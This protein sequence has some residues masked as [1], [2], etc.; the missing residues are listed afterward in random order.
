QRK[1]LIPEV[2]LPQHRGNITIADVLQADPGPAR[3]AMIRQWCQST[4]QACT[5]CH[6]AIKAYLLQQGYQ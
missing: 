4:W 6:E 3:D 5:P 1:A 2:S